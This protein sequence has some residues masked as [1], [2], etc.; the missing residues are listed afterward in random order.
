MGSFS[1]DGGETHHIHSTHG[2]QGILQLEF[3]LPQ[4]SKIILIHDLY[5]MSCSYLWKPIQFFIAFRFLDFP[6]VSSYGSIFIHCA[7]HYISFFN[8]DTLIFQF[9]L[10]MFID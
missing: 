1:V 7:A 9:N 5:Y 4:K 8:L 3:C 2:G 10:D 6:D